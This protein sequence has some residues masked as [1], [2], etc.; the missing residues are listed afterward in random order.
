MIKESEVEGLKR[1][2]KELKETID[3][4]DHSK[5]LQEVKKAHSD[6]T[7]DMALKDI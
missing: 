5:E 4:K 6:L 1:H 3:E 2:I 7:K